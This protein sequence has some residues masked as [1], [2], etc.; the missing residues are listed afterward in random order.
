M[1]LTRTRPGRPAA[2]MPRAT[3]AVV[4]AAVAG[5]AVALFA[6]AWRQPAGGLGDRHQ[7]II[8][9]AMGLLLLA[10]WVWPVVVYRGGESEAFSMD[11]GF[12]VI[13]ALLVP[14]L[15]TLVTFASATA[16][17]Q[18]ARRRPLVKSAFNTGQVLAAAGL[19]LTV[20]RAIAVPPHALSP[21]AIVAIVPGVA[22]YSAVNTILVAAVVV[23][24]GT[25]WREF[26]GDLRIQLTLAGAA[27]L[28][29]AIVALAIEVHI[30]AVALTIPGLIVQRWLISARFAALHDRARMEGLY[31]VTL[32]AN[33]GLRQRAVIETI[34]ASARRLLRSPEASLTSDAPGH[35]QLA[36]AMTVAGEQ[37]WLVASGRRRDEPFD[38]A[39]GSLLRALAAVG[40]GALS[41][42]ELYQQ[43]RLEREWLS[44]ITL[45]MAEGVCAVDADGNLTFVN[46]AAA[47]LIELPS[48]GGTSG[49]TGGTTGTTTGVTTGGPVGADAPPAPGF[50]LAPARETMR[51]GRTIRDDAARFPGQERRHRPGRVYGFRGDKQRR[52]VRRGAHV[53]R[54]H[55]T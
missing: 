21:A 50:L 14:P 39:D 40:D 6:A 49:G 27:V 29:G 23:S 36:A 42:A 22:V 35:D 10:S 3:R 4:A 46:P 8:A 9:A 11:E 24:M 19:G 55:R 48:P 47:D 18:A 32:E 7:W 37:Q 31:Q 44:S 5:G 33:R 12:F 15:L 45:H 34:L 54:H 43:V 20:S 38:D 28:M 1:G 13:L 41:N 17:A 51:T 30:W 25:A 53:P 52:S 2:K 26:T 16:L